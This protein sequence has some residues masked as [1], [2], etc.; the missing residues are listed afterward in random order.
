M[1]LLINL[2]YSVFY[3]A[4]NY[5]IFLCLSRRSMLLKKTSLACIAG[6]V[7]LFIIF[8]MFDNEYFMSKHDLFSILAFSFMLPIIYIFS[9]IQLKVFKMLSSTVL[10]QSHSFGKLESAFNFLRT[11]LIFIMMFLYQLV[12]VWF[13]SAR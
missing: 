6:L 2:L 11:K 7:I 10:T 13:P 4:A 5:V 9:Y 8:A 12:A 1:I 3:A